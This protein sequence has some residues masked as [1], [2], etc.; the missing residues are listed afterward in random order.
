VRVPGLLTSHHP[1]VQIAYPHTRHF[2]ALNVDAP[3]L[4][5]E[6]VSHIS[7]TL[8]LANPAFFQIDLPIR[9]TFTVYLFQFVTFLKVTWEG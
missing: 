9:S 4:P 6:S 3:H 1:Q 7:D 5:A 8:H 2:D